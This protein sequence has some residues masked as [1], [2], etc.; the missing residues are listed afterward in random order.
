M[1]DDQSKKGKKWT[2][3]SKGSPIENPKEEIIVERE[4]V[5][6]TFHH[7]D[8]LSQEKREKVRGLMQKFVDEVQQMAN[9]HKKDS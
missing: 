7:R 4:S 8:E 1:C 2:T 3:I 6:M 5:K 9:K